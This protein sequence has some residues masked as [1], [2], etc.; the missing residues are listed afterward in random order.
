L[1]GAAGCNLC[2][3]LQTLMAWNNLLFRVARWI[4][5]AMVPV[6]YARHRRTLPPALLAEIEWQ[7]PHLN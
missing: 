2:D 4:V 6:L 3:N 5:R 1:K 7:T